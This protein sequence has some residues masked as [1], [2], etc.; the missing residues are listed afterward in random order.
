MLFRSQTLRGVREAFLSYGKAVFTIL[1]SYKIKKNMRTCANGRSRC[2]GNKICREKNESQP[3]S[4]ALTDNQIQSNSFKI[5]HNK[6]KCVEEF[7]N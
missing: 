3:E 1:F 2:G 5:V 4:S 7:V 6:Q